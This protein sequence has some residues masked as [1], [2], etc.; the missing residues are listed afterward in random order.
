MPTKGRELNSARTLATQP[1]AGPSLNFVII[2][3]IMPLDTAGVWGQIW[4]LCLSLYPTC[5][6]PYCMVIF[7]FIFMLTLRRLRLRPRLMRN[8]SNTDISTTVLGH[9]IAFPILIAPMGLQCMAHKDGER[10]TA[11]GKNF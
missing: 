1:A 8:V 9:R 2:I 10:Q 3:V 7:W 11:K 5:F 6:L 4:L